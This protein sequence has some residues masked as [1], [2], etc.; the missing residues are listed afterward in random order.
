MNVSPDISQYLPL[1]IETI[2]LTKVISRNLVDMADLT[3]T[4]NILDAFQAP[5]DASP[6]FGNGSDGSLADDL[7]GSGLSGGKPCGPPRDGQWGKPCGPS[8]RITKQDRCSGKGHLTIEWP[9]PG[10]STDKGPARTRDITS[11]DGYIF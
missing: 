3:N 10:N 11:E 9:R 6:S 4:G 2:D 7:K 5:S 8:E 1:F